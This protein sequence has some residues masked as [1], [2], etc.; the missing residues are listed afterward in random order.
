MA[1]IV[2]K[3]QEV[4]MSNTDNR[5]LLVD[6]QSFHYQKAVD[7]FNIVCNNCVSYYKTPSQLRQLGDIEV[8]VKCRDGGSLQDIA[9]EKAEH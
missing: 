1:V 5:T 3:M 8:C 2:G 4:K 7:G 9:K 6:A